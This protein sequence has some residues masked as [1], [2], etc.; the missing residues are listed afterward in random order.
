MTPEERERMNWLCSEIQK[1]K[2]HDKFSKLVLELDELF[3]KK[4]QRLASNHLGLQKVVP[5]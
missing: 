1:E 2:D 5:E 4:E 3:E